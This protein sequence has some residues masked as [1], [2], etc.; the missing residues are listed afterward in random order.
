MVPASGLR[1]LLCL[2]KKL[3][4]RVQVHKTNNGCDVGFESKNSTLASSK[5]FWG[6]VE[7]IARKYES[8]SRF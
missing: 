1:D 4:E 3:V 2:K 7:K 8:K 6:L 5:L